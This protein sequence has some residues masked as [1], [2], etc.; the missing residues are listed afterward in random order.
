[1]LIRIVR[2]YFQEEKTEDFLNIFEQ[3]KK[4][5][6]NFEGCEHLELWQDAHCPNV[7]CTYSHWIDESYLEKYRQSELFKSTWAKTKI[8]FAEKPQA[9]SVQSILVVEK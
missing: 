4:L 5:I 7:F 2:M 1:M 3:S 6:R 8:L 9:F